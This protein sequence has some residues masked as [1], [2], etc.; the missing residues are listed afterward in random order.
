MHTLEEIIMTLR[1]VL[2][3]QCAIVVDA[4]ALKQCL[5]KNPPRL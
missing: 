2:P 4:M 1:D 3:P 5:S